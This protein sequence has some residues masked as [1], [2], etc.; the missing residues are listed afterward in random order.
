[1]HFS[2]DS[3]VTDF[4]SCKIGIPYVLYITDFCSCKIGIPYVLYITDFGSC[5]IGIPYALYINSVLES[6]C[7]SF[8]LGFGLLPRSRS[9]FRTRL[10]RSLPWCRSSSIHAVVREVLSCAHKKITIVRGTP[11]LFN[12]MEAEISK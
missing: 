5:K 7:M 4:C 1:M 3:C 8:T 9:L 6:L 11:Q 10:Y 12:K 2:R